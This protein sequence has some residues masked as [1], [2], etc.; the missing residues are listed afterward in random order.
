MDGRL[1]PQKVVGTDCGL[2]D[3]GALSDPTFSAAADDFHAV[4]EARLQRERRS[5]DGTLLRH[6]YLAR[7]LAIDRTIGHLNVDHCMRHCHLKGELTA[8]LHAVVCAA[9]VQPALAD[10]RPRR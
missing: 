2:P 4:P 6:A 3:L 9:G 7:R 1:V 5:P 10:T 8:R